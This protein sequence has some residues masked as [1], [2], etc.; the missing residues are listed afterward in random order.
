MRPAFSDWH[1]SVSV[2]IVRFALAAILGA[3]IGL[4]RGW[5][6][7]RVNFRTHILVSTGAALVMMLSIYG[8]AD[9]HLATANHPQN[10]MDPNDE[11]N[12]LADP[13]R[14]VAQVVSGIGFL[15][16]GM[17]LLK[18]GEI[19]GIT[20][21]A[22]IWVVAAVGLCAGAGFYF[23]AILATALTVFVL[24]VLKYIRKYMDKKKT[25]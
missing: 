11:P 7:H 5:K 21:A 25:N 10:P 9:L 17:I 23:G 22:S 24:S 15:G 1:L 13:A 3:I 6:N 18:R 4:E 2:M 20:T 12:M 19:I 8:F 16:A 14:L